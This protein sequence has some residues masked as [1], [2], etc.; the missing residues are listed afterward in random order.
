MNKY[1][2]I[3][4]KLGMWISGLCII[5]CLLVPVIVSIYPFF[6]H[7]FGELLFHKIL[8]LVIL[9][10]SVFAF[11]P[12]YKIHKRKKPIILLFSGLTCL[13]MNILFHNVFHNIELYINILGSLLIITAHLKNKKHCSQCK[14]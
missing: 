10:I 9:F 7:R 11:I 1:K 6:F 5:H 14:H 3:Y 8:F 13:S 4:D 12:G 2:E